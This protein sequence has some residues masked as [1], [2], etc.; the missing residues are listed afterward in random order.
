MTSRHKTWTTVG[1][2]LL[3]GVM[4]SGC[5]TQP[6]TEPGDAM[7]HYRAGRY[8]QAFAAGEQQARRGGL[9]GD[10]GKYIAG[11]S[12]YR[13]GRASQALSRLTPLTSH[14]A[15]DI[16]GPASATVGLIH[17]ARGRHA[18]AITYFKK[19]VENLRGEDQA[20]AYFH[21]GNAEQKLGRWSSARTHMSLAIS[22]SDDSAFRRAVR[23]RMNASAFTLQ[24]GAFS[25][26]SNAESHARKIASQ[27]RAAGLGTPSV[28]TASS[29]GKT[30][31]LVQ[32]GQYGTYDSALS[33]R[34]RLNRTDVIITRGG[35]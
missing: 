5:E 13:L 21:L 7:A 4:A 17:T 18:Q 31:Y 23:E 22:R 1:L 12:A 32:V 2:M 6:K 8:E 3:L 30:L 11:M 15:N 25:S 33:A 20:Q 34:R 9:T 16:A 14:R 29:S 10:Q 26:R 28:V 24:F 27:T 19:A 35:D